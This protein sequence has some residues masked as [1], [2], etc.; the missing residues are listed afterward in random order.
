MSA[1]LMYTPLESVFESTMEREGQILA[2]YTSGKEFRA[3]FRI[4]NDNEN[5]RETVVI[6]YDVT[7]PVRSGTLVM[8]GNDIYLVLNKETI[9]NYV[10]YKSTL[11]KC[12]GVYNSNDGEI[13]NV[14]FYTD[15]MK[16][17]VSVGNNIISMLNGNIE[18]LT[19]ENSIT[20]KININTIFNEFGRTF[21]ITNKYVIDGIMHIISEVKADEEPGYE[22]SIKIG[23]FPENKIESNAVIQL[24]ATPYVNDN[25]A[26]GATFEWR[27]SDEKVAMVDNTGMV[28]CLSKGI[29]RITVTW[30]EK[31]VSKTLDI[32]V[33][34]GEEE[35]DIPV[36]KY[37]IS[38]NPKLRVGYYRTYTFIVLDEFGN[39]LENTDCVWNVISDFDVKQDI[40]GNKIILSVDNEDLI[41]RK[42]M[43]QAIY[44][45]KIVAEIEIVIVE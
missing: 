32:T 25:I 41:G 24:I 13:T 35:P 11:I 3:F 6:Y 18:I 5:Q 28:T 19:E 9:E 22:Y 39:P 34:N 4:R 31:D 26:L 42:I 30:V 33:V 38:G 44:D 12:N 17:S 15:N 1:N 7:A 16:S 20:K 23:G 8:I 37:G 40:S 29:A 36:Y 27:S 14:P 10:Y 21:M 2:T 45:V 43:L